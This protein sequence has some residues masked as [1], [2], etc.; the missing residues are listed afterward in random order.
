MEEEGATLLWGT[1]SKLLDKIDDEL[2]RLNWDKA[3]DMICDAFGE[4]SKE[5]DTTEIFFTWYQFFF[6]F[7]HRIKLMDKPE[8][9]N[10]VSKTTRLINHDNVPM[11]M[12]SNYDI[13]MYKWAKGKGCSENITNNWFLLKEEDLSE[14]EKRKLD[15]RI[16]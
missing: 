6:R 3:I 1:I 13:K 7:Y 10:A 5:T 11:Y 4:A 8:Q 2:T 16:A 12:I 14:S 15:A 9:F